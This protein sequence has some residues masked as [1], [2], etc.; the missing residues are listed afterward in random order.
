MGLALAIKS[1]FNLN[2]FEFTETK[3]PRRQ[4]WTVIAIV[5]IVV[6]Y[7]TWVFSTYH[8]ASARP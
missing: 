4:K 5:T 3:E 7:E 1:I 6:V 2:C 8:K